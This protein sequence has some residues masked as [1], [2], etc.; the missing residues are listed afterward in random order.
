M[1]IRAYDT[2]QQSSKREACLISFVAA[3][4]SQCVAIAPCNA[5]YMR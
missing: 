2:T 1:K 4:C 5:G 3:L